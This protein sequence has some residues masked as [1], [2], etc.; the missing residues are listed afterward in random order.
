MFLSPLQNKE[1]AGQGVLNDIDGNKLA[2]YDSGLN[3]PSIFAHEI[4]HVL[5]L[6]HSFRTYHERETIDMFNEE[7]KS[8]D[9]IYQKMLDANTPKKIIAQ[10]W[11]LDKER[12]KDLRSY[13]NI[14]YR[15]KALTFDQ[16]TTEN[17]MDYPD[18]RDS[19][20]Q[21][22]RKN[23]YKKISYHKY[24]WKAMQ[25]DVVKFYSKKKL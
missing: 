19:N 14:H 12:Y 17:F 18:L 20:N 23:P 1:M 25:D 5:G 16:A 9:R 6:T 4:S 3:K 11:K 24:Q 22:I 2:I 10:K 7:I 15:N 21:I 8:F 13:L